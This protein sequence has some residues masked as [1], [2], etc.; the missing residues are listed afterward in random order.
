MNVV[1]SKA[2]KAVGEM[3]DKMSDI[4]A[5]PSSAQGAVAGPL[6]D[7]V[8]M[9]LPKRATLNRALQRHRK[10]LAAATNGGVGLPPLPVARHKQ[11]E[12]ASP[13][14][15]CRGDSSQDQEVP[16]PHRAR[17][18]SCSRIRTKPRC[19][20]CCVL[21]HICHMPDWQLLEQYIIHVGTLMLF[22]V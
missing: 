4:G 12:G 6:A 15:R 14:R 21:W 16:W 10:K 19:W 9:G 1:R 2:R 5:T 17:Q 7:Y 20:P 3:K 22:K 11:A 18:Q 13:A 8:L